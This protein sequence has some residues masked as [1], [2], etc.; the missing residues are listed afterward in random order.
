MS[1]PVSGA[2]VEF[3]ASGRPP[4][5]VFYALTDEEGEFSNVQI[6]EDEGSSL[7]VTVRAPGYAPYSRIVGT[8]YTLFNLPPLEIPLT[9]ILPNGRS[10]LNGDNIVDAHDLLI[11]LA[12]WKKV[13]DTGG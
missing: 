10:D 5:S 9:P 1:H 4:D 2:S 3:E 13:T 12:D 7:Y 6:C 8:L 11:L